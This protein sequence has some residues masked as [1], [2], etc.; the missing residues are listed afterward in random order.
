MPFPTVRQEYFNSDVE[1]SVSNLQIVIN[2]GR[3]IRDVKNVP[4]KMPVR[5]L[6]VIHSDPQFLKDL[7]SLKSYIQEVCN[8]KLKF[9]LIRN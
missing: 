4:L 7:E 8:L 5:E 2:L 9:I 1:R 6:V 3:N